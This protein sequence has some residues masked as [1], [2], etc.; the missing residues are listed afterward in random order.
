MNRDVG[1]IFGYDSTGCAVS[2]FIERSV[3]H[4]EYDYDLNDNDI[5]ILILAGGIDFEKRPCACTACLS[6]RI[7]QPAEWCVVSGFGEESN[8]GFS[9]YDSCL[10]FFRRFPISS[11]TEPRKFSEVSHAERA[12]PVADDNRAL[13]REVWLLPNATCSGTSPSVGSMVFTFV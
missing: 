2:F 13:H 9:K 11:S 8:D 10:R 4:P 3:I 5:A 6:L 12:L 1:E 7:P